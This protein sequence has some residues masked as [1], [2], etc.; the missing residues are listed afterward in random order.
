MVR[1]P[2]VFCGYLGRQEATAEMID[3]DGWLHTG[4]I[5]TE[6]EDGYLAITGRKKGIIITSGG[7]NLSPEKIENALKTS[8]YIKEAIAIGDRRKFISALVQVEFDTLSHWA[9]RNAIAY[10]S[11]ADLSS[12]AEVRALVEKEID[13]AN[14]KLAKVEQVRKFHLLD[15]ELSQEDGELTATQKVRR[16]AV[17]TSYSEL[18]DGIYGGAA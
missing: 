2:S 3:E 12:R 13:A 4:D 15:K 5:G 10:T 6:D 9:T 7:K 18:V 11:F 1:G 16:S 17:L 8:P 14:D